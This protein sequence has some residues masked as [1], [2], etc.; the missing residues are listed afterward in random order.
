MSEPTSPA[1]ANVADLLQRIDASWS[2]FL[3]SL[4]DLREDQLLEPNAV[5]V[6]SL[7]E[8]L[9]HIAFWDNLGRE[10]A[11]R[12]LAGNVREFD[13]YEELN[14][15][16]HAA[17]Q[18]R[19]LAEERTAMHQ[20]HA[21][22]VADLEARAELEAAAIDRAIAGATYEHYDEHL[23]DVRAWREKHGIPA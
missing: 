6:W 2:V 17:R 13:D 14:Q 18:G 21:A 19:T 5:G 3:A 15:A 1:P 10:N 16:D 8:L 7:K 20:A 22:L 23:A 12:A 9:G 4:D 11:A